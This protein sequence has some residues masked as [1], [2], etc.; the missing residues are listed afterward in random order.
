MTETSQNSLQ[1]TP[2]L[3]ARGLETPGLNTSPL[4]EYGYDRLDYGMTISIDRTPAGRLWACWVGGGDSE[5]G[6]F[7]LA[8]SDDDGQSWSD[9]RLVI[10]PHD[11]A[12]P[13]ARRSLVGVLWTDPLGRLW[14]F[15]DQSLG[16]FD[17]RAGDWVTRCDN[18]DA[19]QP[20][21][22]PPERLWHGMTL[23][24]P[25]VLANGD[26]LLPIALWTRDRIDGRF[27]ECFPELDP[28][29]MANVFVSTDEGASW[30]RRGGA[31]FP[32]TDFDEHTIVQR[33][34]GTLW[35]LARTL[36]SIWESVSHDDGRSWSTP[37]RSAIEHI[38]ARFHLRRLQS[39]RILLVKHGTRVGERT[40][41]RSHLT[42]FLSDDDGATWCGGLLLDERAVIS[43]PDGTQA[44]D[45]TIYVSYDRNRATDGEIL[46]ARFT[47]EDVLAGQP[48]SPR[49]CLQCRITRACEH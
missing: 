11:P 23:N 38:S 16:Y 27:A 43:Y 4:P 10:D 39:G 20:V 42:A 34:D 9:P 7:V 14:L 15:F 32:R 35:M 12:L 46:L 49:A 19:D 2:E 28:L 44:P 5:K 36:D 33:R 25:T 40:E 24:K 17:G 1:I 29:R 48:V 6:F 26:W 18:P 3:L 37:E 31:V 21:W 30:A 22:S 13:C 8:S 47:E 41:V 45:G